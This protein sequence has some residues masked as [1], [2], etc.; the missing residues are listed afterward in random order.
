[1]LY[2]ES[3]IITMSAMPEPF[4]VTKELADLLGVLAHPHRIRIIEELREMERDVNTLQTALGISH[5]GAS[6]HLSVLRAHRLVAERREG[7]H[8]YYHLRQPKLARWLVEGIEFVAGTQEVA[9]DVRA[10]IES[11]RAKWATEK[12]E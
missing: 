5:S 8:V 12:S 3:V 7:R 2:Y 9:E 10:A 1:M 11:M 4:L 6:Q